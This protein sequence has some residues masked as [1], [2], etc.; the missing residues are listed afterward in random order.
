MTAQK[1]DRIRTFLSELLSSKGDSA[2]FGDADPLYTQGR[3]DSLNLIETVSF[4]EAEFGLDLS[5][6]AFDTSLIDSVDAIVLLTD[7]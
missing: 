5:T 4:L 2:P 3:I 1:R 7:K 6:L